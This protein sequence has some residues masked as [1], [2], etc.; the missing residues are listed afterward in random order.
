MTVVSLHPPVYQIIDWIGGST[1][2]L[3]LIFTTESV[4][5]LSQIKKDGLHGR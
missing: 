2:L 1:V 5:I 4:D 3:F